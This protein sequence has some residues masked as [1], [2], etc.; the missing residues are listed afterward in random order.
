MKRIALIFFA[1]LAIQTMSLAQGGDRPNRQF[2]PSERIANEK[3]EV[4]EKITDL[5]E[6]QKLL[7]D[8]VYKQFEVTVK[9]T[10]ASGDRENM[11]AQFQEN[12]KKKDEAMKDILS[13]DQ[14]KL[15]HE[16]TERSPRGGRGGRRGDND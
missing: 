1:L 13:E 11:R 8:E 3:K 14:F 6:D 10:I 16:V 5:N 12:R 2:D 7:I 15:Y 4:L 9:E